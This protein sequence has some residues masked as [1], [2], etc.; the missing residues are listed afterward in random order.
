VWV[1]KSFTRGLNV[2][3]MED[4][5][6]SPTWQDSARTAMGQARRLADEVDLAAMVPAGDLSSTRYCLAALGREYLVFQPGSLGL[7][8][9]DLKDVAGT[10]SVEW[11][12]VTTGGTSSAEAVTGGG[13]RAFSTPFGG[14][15]VLHLECG[16]SE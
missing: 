16:P 15:A 4:L 8:R 13:R 2:L 11:L 6:P 14:P 12:N 10:C 7:F 5:P 9:V 1:W 3:L